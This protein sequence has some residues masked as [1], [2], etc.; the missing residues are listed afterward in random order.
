MD[1]FVAYFSLG[2]VRLGK[3]QKTRVCSITPSASFRQGK[4]MGST[5]D[6]GKPG[7][8]CSMLNSWP[9]CSALTS[10]YLKKFTYCCY[11]TLKVRVRGK[12]W[13]HTGGTHYHAQ[14]G[15]PDK[16]RAI[17]RVG[18]LLCSMVPGTGP[19]FWSGWLSSSS[20]ATPNRYVQIQYKGQKTPTGLIHMQDQSLLQETKSLPFIFVKK[21]VLFS[22]VENKDK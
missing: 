14:L 9:R 1:V 13:P 21:R 20:T 7:T 12:S 22:L 16:S 15:L 2:L 4:V 17:K 19:L 11:A 5:L 10:S 18:C 8:L 6:R 3:G